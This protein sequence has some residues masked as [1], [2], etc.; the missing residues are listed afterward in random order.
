MREKNSALILIFNWIAHNPGI[1]KPGHD[2][3]T[4]SY[5]IIL[6]VQ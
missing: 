4:I 2:E 5:A 6:Q 1:M 3:P